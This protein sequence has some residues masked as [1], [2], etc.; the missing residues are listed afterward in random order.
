MS[1][2][3]TILGTTYHLSET[4]YPADPLLKD[5]DGYCHD[6][7]KK[8]V[9]DKNKSIEHKRHVLTHEIVHAFLNESGL[10]DPTGWGCNEE[11]VD[12]IATQLPKMS[13]VVEEALKEIK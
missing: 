10:K 6:Y 7:A 11:I 1:K 8:I 12:W 2:K 3:I 4:V 5:M 9:L 13:K